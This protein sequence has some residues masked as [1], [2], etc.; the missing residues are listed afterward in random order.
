MSSSPPPE[1]PLLPSQNPSNWRFTWE[2]QSH[3]PTIRLY[4][5]NP[6]AKPSSQCTEL[7]SELL[8]EKSS[9]LVSFILAGAKT[10]LKVPLPKALIDP[11]SPVNFRAHDDHI[12]FKCPLLFPI[13]HPL[14]S[15]F[16]FASSGELRPLSADT[17]AREL[18]AL[19]EV[20]FYCRNC[21]TKL[22]KSL[23]CFKVLPSV[24]W[25]EA[26]DNWFGTCCCSFGG[27][28]EK[29]V[30]KYAKSYS[31]CAGTCLLDTASVNLCKDDL[32][33][34]HFP[35]NNG[36]KDNGFDIKL[37]S[38]S[39]VTQTSATD[40]SDQGRTVLQ[41]VDGG[42]C[43]VALEDGDTKN[44]VDCDRLSLMY[45]QLHVAENLEKS[46][47]FSSDLKND[48][49]KCDIGCCDSHLSV[50]SFKR[51]DAAKEN[52]LQMH[53]KVLL[54]GFLSNGLIARSSNLSKD[55]N[56]VEF[57]CPHCSSVLGAYPSLS[58]Y[59]PLDGGVRLFKCHISSSLPVGGFNDLF[60]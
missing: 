40:I 47:N 59:A 32:L 28:S 42:G 8:I 45:S 43:H 3:I 20:Y 46:A 1:I 50:D 19:E 56:W 22:T 16:D 41:N 6:H 31:C 36:G 33:G 51:E 37:A 52:E 29:L 55:V 15:E 4:L 57:L 13:D 10:S 39:S 14:V 54:N 25:Q 53:Q 35:V 11:E 27:I 58:D 34:C 21:S 18:S 23:S 17:D 60:R 49:G 7:K 5:F 48:V 38:N 30:A 44:G 26:A 12:E 2:A 24:N 9:L